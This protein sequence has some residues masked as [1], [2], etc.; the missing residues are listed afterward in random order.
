MLESW[1]FDSTQDKVT[2]EHWSPQV[3]SAGDRR[4]RRTSPSYAPLRVHFEV[5]GDVSLAVRSRLEMTV[6][7]RVQRVLQTSFRVIPVS[8]NLTLQ[9]PTSGSVFCGQSSAVVPESHLSRGGAGIEADTVVYISGIGCGTSSGTLGYSATCFRDQHDRPIAG[10]VVLCPRGQQADDNSTVALLLH[11]AVHVLGFAEASYRYFRDC[12]MGAFNSN[13]DYVCPPRVARNTNGQPVGGTGDVPGILTIDTFGVTRMNSPSVVAAARS[14]FGCPTLTNVPLEDE[15][16]RSSSGQHWEARLLAYDIMNSVITLGLGDKYFLS[17]ITTALLND[18]G[19]YEAAA[20]ASLSEISGT[21]QWGRDGGCEILDCTPTTLDIPVTCASCNGPTF[22]NPSGS[23]GCSYDRLD[24]AL[25]NSSQFLNGCQAFLPF[26]G[27]S[28][29]HSEPT[30]APPGESFGSSSRCFDAAGTS[31]SAKC[32]RHRC[33]PAGRLLAEARIG[34]FE[35]CTFDGYALSS[36][37][38]CPNPS[39]LCPATNI[40]YSSQALLIEFSVGGQS[41]GLA[42]YDSVSPFLEQLITTEFDVSD[43]VVTALSVTTRRTRIAVDIELS[44]V[45]NASGSSRIDAL[46]D[47][48][49]IFIATGRVYIVVNG[50]RVP[51]TLYSGDD[52]LVADASLS[53][54]ERLITGAVVVAA[55]LVTCVVVVLIAVQVRRRRAKSVALT[56]DG[57]VVMGPYSEQT[58]AV[59]KENGMPPQELPRHRVRRY[60]SGPAAEDMQ[61]VRITRHAQ[62]PQV[63][64]TQESNDGAHGQVTE[65]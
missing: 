18:S 46:M 47:E 33:H 4:I 57:P 41:G 25:C 56:H 14:F 3:Y 43:V 42:L 9:A 34:E 58:L 23:R 32:L 30:T 50:E 22:C 1:E 52:E 17:E 37:V 24:K 59:T 20:T 61:T 7:P 51:A 64:P 12:T 5:L 10:L 26:V 13:G 63:A 27:G 65:L 40:Q 31:T 53:T 8:G 48:L 16:S 55:A 11:E 45:V 49:G 38:L 36:S 60:N 29:V 21:P 15:G 39:T 6:I 19:W 2:P 28:C 62:Y 54:S 44:A 35:A